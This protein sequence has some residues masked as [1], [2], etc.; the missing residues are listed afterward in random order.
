MHLGIYN[1]YLW[2]AGK[3]QFFIRDTSSF[4]LVFPIVMLVCR[5]VNLKIPWN[6][7][8][9]PKG[10]RCKAQQMPRKLLSR[11]LPMQLPLF[12]HPVPRFKIITGDAKAMQVHPLVVCF[13]GGWLVAPPPPPPSIFF[14]FWGG[15]WQ[16]GCLFF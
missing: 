10:S 16:G 1:S 11:D 8:P 15:R 7:L 3:S 4:L 5:S 12:R 13:C 14:F 9:T 6:I 2:L